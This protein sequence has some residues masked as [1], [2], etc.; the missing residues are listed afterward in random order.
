MAET[1]EDQVTPEVEPE[2]TTTTT[3]KPRAKKE[4]PAE[5]VGGGE[6]SPEKDAEVLAQNIEQAKQEAL[7]NH[8]D[9]V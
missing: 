7:R 2:T 1:T 8:A 3:K 4:A 5:V 9:Q 6:T